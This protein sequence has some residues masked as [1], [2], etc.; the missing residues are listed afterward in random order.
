MYRLL[1]YDGD[2]ES[3][4]KSDNIIY[5]ETLF[6]LFR[7]AYLQFDTRKSMP[8]DWTDRQSIYSSYLYVLFLIPLSVKKD[9]DAH[10][11][12]ETEWNFRRYILSIGTVKGNVRLQ[13]LRQDVFVEL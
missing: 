12:Y 5:I 3:I 13:T 11:C 9:S 4:L 10:T 1:P 7:S 8:T 6:I 2:L